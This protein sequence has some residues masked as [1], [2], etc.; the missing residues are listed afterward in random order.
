M[1]LA[2]TSAAFSM[3]DRMPV[4][5]TGDGTDISPPMQW[6][7]PPS[8]TREFAL[9]CDDPDAPTAEP[10]VHW[11]LYNLLPD[12]R[13]LPEGMVTSGTPRYPPGAA[14][15]QNSWGRNHLGYRGPAPPRGHGMHHYHFKLYALDVALNLK[16]GIDK[17]DLLHAMDKHVIDQG[18]LVGCYERK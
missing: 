5:F 12:V 3:G 9:I 18:D 4:R 2:L 6:T 17:V 7:D 15:G 1:T 8:G 13:N 14:Q 10:W 16:P 11:L